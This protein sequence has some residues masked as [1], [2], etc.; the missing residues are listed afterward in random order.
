[1]PEERRIGISECVQQPITRSGYNDW[2]RRD[3]NI[4]GSA[5]DSF[6]DV[7]RSIG[8][9][10]SGFAMVD[11]DLANPFRRSQGFVAKTGAI[12]PD[13]GHRHIHRVSGVVRRIMNLL[14]N[15]VEIL[16]AESVVNHLW[17]IF[18]QR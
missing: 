1:M 18:Q 6:A 15:S 16:A 5:R 8:G 9:P 3:A 7:T 4:R 17:M 13:C 10:A 12:D 11:L 2:T 14:F